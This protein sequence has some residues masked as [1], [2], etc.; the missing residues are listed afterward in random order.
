M[1]PILT[2]YS[3]IMSSEVPESSKGARMSESYPPRQDYN[4]AESSIRAENVHAVMMPYEYTSEISL[5]DSEMQA[6]TQGVHFS[7]IDIHNMVDSFN[8]SLSDLF[9][10]NSVDTTEENIQSRVRGTLLMALSNKHHK[11]V[12][13]DSP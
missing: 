6:R 9:E 12:R 13:P 11:I 7:N 10:N 8:D 1:F 2:I 3:Q 5:T 4:F